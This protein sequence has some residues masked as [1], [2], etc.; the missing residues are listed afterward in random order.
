MVLTMMA[1]LQQAIRHWFG[2]ASYED[3]FGWYQLAAGVFI[4]LQPHMG[5]AW[6]ID[7][8]LPFITPQ[9]FGVVMILSGVAL[10]AIDGRVSPIQ[11]YQLKRWPLFIW[12]LYIAISFIAAIRPYPLSP[13]AEPGLAQIPG[14]V[15]VIYVFTG[16]ILF[17]QLTRLRENAAHTQI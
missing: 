9:I 15:V 11:Q 2:R 4:L 6:F 8:Q 1:R 7:S 14:V 17:S 10:V 5:I 3:K 12:Y 13:F 16:D